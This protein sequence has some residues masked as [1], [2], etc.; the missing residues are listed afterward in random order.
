MIKSE[1][2]PEG[3]PGGVRRA[4]EFG[5]A[6]IQVVKLD[7]TD[8]VLAGMMGRDPVPALD[9]A[10]LFIETNNNSSHDIAFFKVLLSTCWTRVVTAHA[11]ICDR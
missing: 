5:K 1:I 4:G 7:G 9:A 3:S 10:E 11:G 6:V 2:Q 8:F